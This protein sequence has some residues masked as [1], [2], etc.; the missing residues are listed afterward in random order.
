MCLCLVD[1]PSGTLAGWCV[2][3][4]SMDRLEH[5][6][7]GV[8]APRRQTN[9]NTCRVVCLRLVDRPTG[10]L[11]GWCICSSP[12]NRLEHLQGGVSAPRQQTDWNTCRVM[13]LW[14]GLVT[15]APCRRSQTNC[16]PNPMTRRRDREQSVVELDGSLVQSRCGAR[17]G[18]PEPLAGFAPVL[19]QRHR[20]QGPSLFALLTR[21][22]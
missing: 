17:G 12:T 10:T 4:S 21:A 20:G 18:S 9:W 5:L 13:C 19:A 14:T 7:G 22:R 1:G 16:C 6:Q 2:C 15:R 11:A 3:A 8:S